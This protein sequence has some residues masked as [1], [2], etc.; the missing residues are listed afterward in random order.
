MTDKKLKEDKPANEQFQEQLKR[1]LFTSHKSAKNFYETNNI[2]TGILM[3]IKTALSSS[4]LLLKAAG[5]VLYI[6][7]MLPS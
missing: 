7:N 3:K 6:F 2:I 1:L 5:A 4:L